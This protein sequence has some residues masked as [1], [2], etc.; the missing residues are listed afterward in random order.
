[1]VSTTPVFHPS[2]T[3]WPESTSFIG[4]EDGAEKEREGGIY[5][6]VRLYMSV[7]LAP[8]IQIITRCLLKMPLFGNFFCTVCMGQYN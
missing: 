5:I 8:V 2:A 6:T 4:R 7:Y 1:M 3:F